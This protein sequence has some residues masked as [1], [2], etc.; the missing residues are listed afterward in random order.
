MPELALVKMNDAVAGV[1]M[2]DQ[3]YYFFAYDEHY[4]AAGGQPLSLSL[5]VTTDIYES[6]HLFAY[7]DGLVAEGW[8]RRVQSQF[9]K[10]DDKDHFALLV[11]NGLDLA[12]AVT[13]E[14]YTPQEAHTTKGL[15][16]GNL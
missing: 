13:I 14:P 7:F 12:G 4:I 1:L 15:V 11:N 10:I 2:R 9:Q 8:L 16:H 5:P 6:T 3:G